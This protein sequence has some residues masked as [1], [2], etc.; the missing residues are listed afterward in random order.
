MK[1]ADPTITLLPFDRS[2]NKLKDPT[3]IPDDE[4]A[5]EYAT[6]TLEKRTLSG[7]FTIHTQKTLYHLK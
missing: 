4:S 2:E 7:I 5:S 6:M 3:H 1:Q